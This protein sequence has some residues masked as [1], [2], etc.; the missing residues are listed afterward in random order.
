[1]VIVSIKLN[2]G[3]K[4]SGIC[5]LISGL[6]AVCVMVTMRASLQSKSVC[7]ILSDTSDAVK[8]GQSESGSWIF[9]M[10]TDIKGTLLSGT[11]GTTVTRNCH[12]FIPG[13]RRLYQKE[14]KMLVGSNIETA[15]ED[16][17]C[18]KP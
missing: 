1:M 10:Q 9:T 16:W 15:F 11:E 4:I 3:R 17:F 13:F 8:Q 2:S 12:P 6:G 5:V 18:T 14:W 7:L